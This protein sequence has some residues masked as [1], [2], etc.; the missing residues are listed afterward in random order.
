MKSPYIADLQAGQIATGVFLVHY[1]DVRSKKSG[2]LTLTLT[3]ADRTGDIDARMWDNVDKVVD[4]FERDDFVRVKGLAQIHQNRLQ[5]TLH[6]LVRVDEAEVDL[7]DFFSAS[8][9]DPEEMFTELRGV[10]ASINDRHLRG[11]LEA[12]FGDEEIARK[13]KRA[14]AAKSIHHAWLGGLLEHVLS[15]CALCRLVCPRYPHIDQ[16]LV[17]TGA[18]LHD[19]G[20]I[21]ELTYDRGFN[22]S[23]SGQLIGHILQGMRIVD[24]KIRAIPN[25]P[26]RL[27]MLVNHLIISHHG[28][29]E[30]GSPKV[31]MFAEAMLL[32]HLDNLDSK[33]ETIRGAIERDKLVEGNWTTMVHSLDR[34]ILK[35]EKFLGLTPTPRGPAATSTPS[36]KPADHER[37]ARSNSVFAERLKSALSGD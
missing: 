7:G 32:H 8:A 4:T 13:F 5:F 28:E 36:P 22:Y 16:D 31:P 10:I 1:K 14:P 23:D 19:V 34:P 29:L 17:L 30:F 33:I 35:K 24:D 25:F 6:T 9:R 37:P 15:L 21:D 11:L 2:D 27:Q 26:S 12:V 20:K 3:L 18:I